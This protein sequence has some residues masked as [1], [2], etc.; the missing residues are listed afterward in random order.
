M[1]SFS[2]AQVIDLISINNAGVYF[3]PMCMHMKF[4]YRH[5]VTSG[6]G[7]KRAD[8]KRSDMVFYIQNI[9]CNKNNAHISS[10][11]SILSIL[12]PIYNELMNHRPRTVYHKGISALCRALSH[13]FSVH[14]GFT[15]CT[16][17]FIQYRAFSHNAIDSSTHM[18]GYGDNDNGKYQDGC[19]WQTTPAEIHINFRY[20][21]IHDNSVTLLPTNLEQIPDGQA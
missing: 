1:T 3:T 11:M 4:V 10:D 18:W 14:I 12:V 2:H 19:Y 13:G 16:L 17:F 8:Y 20:A 21:S 5:A 9:S 6:V 15:V 7:E